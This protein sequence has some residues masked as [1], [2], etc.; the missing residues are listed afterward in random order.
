M[1]RKHKDIRTALEAKGFVPEA[2]RKHIHFVFEDSE[3]KTT[4]ARTM[5]SHDAGSSD[6]GDGLLGKMARQIGISRA[7]FLSLV[8]CPLS[9]EELEAKVAARESNLT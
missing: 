9:K 3:G 7:E 1:P 4:T 8:D 2:T 6:I 5:L